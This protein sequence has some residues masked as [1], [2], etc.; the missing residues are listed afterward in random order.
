M[1]AFLLL[2]FSLLSFIYSYNCTLLLLIIIILSYR[3]YN[4]MYS[5]S[6]LQYILF[7]SIERRWEE[8]LIIKLIFY[9]KK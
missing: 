1:N 4:G 8:E 5:E 6:V 9:K 2:F 7:Y 3:L